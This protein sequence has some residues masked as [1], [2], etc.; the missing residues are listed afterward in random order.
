MLRPEVSQPLDIF[1]LHPVVD[2][3]W[4]GYIFIVYLIDIK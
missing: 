2:A 3:L 1:A 4:E